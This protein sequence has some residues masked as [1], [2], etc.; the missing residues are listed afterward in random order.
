MKR[1]A[2]WVKNGSCKVRSTV[3]MDSINLKCHSTHLGWSY[4]FFPTTEIYN[5]PYPEL[6]TLL[7]QGLKSLYKAATNLERQWLK[8]A[9]LPQSLPRLKYQQTPPSRANKNTRKKPTKPVVE[10][11]TDEHQVEMSDP[12]SSPGS[13]YDDVEKSHKS[14]DP[15]ASTQPAPPNA[16]LSEFMPVKRELWES[17][18]LSGLAIMQERL[19]KRVHLSSKRCVLVFSLAPSTNVCL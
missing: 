16:S 19:G 3:K 7:R 18:L 10:P 9:L 11:S 15:S 14:V 2:L 5:M 8:E 6:V 12:N 17:Q 1:R 13:A 4:I